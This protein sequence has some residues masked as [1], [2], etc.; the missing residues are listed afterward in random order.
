M[1]LVRKRGHDLWRQWDPETDDPMD[2]DVEVMHVEPYVPSLREMEVE[3]KRSVSHLESCV[4]WLVVL[5]LLLCLSIVVRLN[6]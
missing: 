4:V 1:K 2:S 5:W 3:L 6:W